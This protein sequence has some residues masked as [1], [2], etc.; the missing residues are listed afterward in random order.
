MENFIRVYDDVLEPSFCN[1]V[2]QRFEASDGKFRGQVH[3]ERGRELNEK[4][5]RTL[6]LVISDQPEWSDVEHTLKQ[7][8]VECVNQYAQEFPH[9]GGLPGQLISEAFRI[10]KYAVGDFFDWHM[11]C[12]GN[13]FFRIL[14]IQFYFNDVASG[15]ATEFQFQQAKVASAQGRVVLFPTLWTYLHRG[16]SVQSN[17][18]YVCTNY[19]RLALDETPNPN[20]P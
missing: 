13:G 16:A 4:K 9:V 17:P 12:V 15:G 20:P 14:A 8:Y 5:K 6:E 18:K 2:I 3:G 10:K 1:D 19:V 7:K 11:D